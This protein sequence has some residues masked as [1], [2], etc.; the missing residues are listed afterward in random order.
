[1]TALASKVDALADKQSEVSINWGK[2][3]IDQL[4]ASIVDVLDERMEG[5]AKRLSEAVS[6]SDDQIQEMEI[7]LVKTRKAL[8]RQSWAMLLLALVPFCVAFIIFGSLLWGIGGAIGLPV[9]YPAMWSLV[10]GAQTWW[11]A[12]LW[13]LLPLGVTAGLIY[14]VYLCGRWLHEKY[15]GW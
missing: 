1:M 8:N 15:K 10:T 7:R 14:V 3:S 6:V 5:H 12:A 11:G 4:S 13:A 2:R 9:I